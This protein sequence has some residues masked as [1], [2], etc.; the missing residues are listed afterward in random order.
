MAEM[1]DAAKTL[2]EGKTFWHLATA[3]AD[4]SPQVSPVW[5]GS[6]DG[7]IV[8]NTAIG[9]VKDK[10]MR[11]EPRVALSAI[12]DNPYEPTMVRGRVAEIVEGDQAEKDIDDLSEKYTGNTPYP[13]RSEGERRVTFLIEPTS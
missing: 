6:R 7:K 3:N 4:G 12:G 10:N 9:R 8:V 2:L 13:W 11:R 5:A 1:N